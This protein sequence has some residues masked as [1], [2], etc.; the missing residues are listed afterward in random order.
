M[1]TKKTKPKLIP[2]RAYALDDTG[3]PITRQTFYRWEAR[4]LIP[5]LLRIGGKTLVQATT[6]DA[7]ESGEIKLPQN[8][9]RL[10]RPVPH[11]RGGWTKKGKRKAKA[12]AE[13]DQPATAAE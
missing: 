11:D 12:E 4:G 6:I 2:P 13:P 5:P 3:L 9:G 1:E 8:A 7:I 10:K